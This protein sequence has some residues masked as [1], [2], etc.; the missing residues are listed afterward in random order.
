MR[1][2]WIL[3][4]VFA[5]ATLASLA[6]VEARENGNPAVAGDDTEAQ[7]AQA[8]ASFDDPIAFPHDVHVQEYQIDCQYCHF[9]VERS[10]SA[11]LPPMATCMGCHAVVDGSENPE[12]VERLREFWEEREPIPWNRIYKVSDHVQFPHMRH[13]SAGVDCAT[14]HGDVEGMGVIEEVEQ[15]LTMGWCVNCHV[16]EQASIDCAVCHY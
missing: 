13:I 2:Q 14:C 15:E 11:G 5:V 9:S 7:A 12:E 8:Q 6:F 3:A 1:K 10:S 4:A 16:E